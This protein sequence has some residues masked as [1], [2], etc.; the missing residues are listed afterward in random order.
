MPKTTCLFLVLFA[1]FP[2]AGYAEAEEIRFVA[3]PYCP[4]AC[5]GGAEYDGMMVDV[6][7]TIFESE[8]YSVIYTTRPWARALRESRRGKHTGLIATVPAESSDFYYPEEEGA[9]LTHCFY[10]R[11]DTPW[12]FEN[13]ESLQSVRLGVIL[14]YGYASISP[15]FGRYVNS[16][17]ENNKL[18]QWVGGEIANLQNFKK[19]VANRIDTVFVDTAVATYWL[20]KSGF[21]DQVRK[22]GCLNETAPLYV[23]FSPAHPASQKYAEIYDR[24][25]RKLRTS[26]KLEEMLAKYEMKDWND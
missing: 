3:E 8:G 16:N 7:R 17:K 13:I 24:G 12:R 19:L 5:Q 22:G 20:N 18:I 25:L 2:C 14:G 26:G 11:N 4:Y 9:R 1:C 10:V 23:A 21:A 6:T 15:E